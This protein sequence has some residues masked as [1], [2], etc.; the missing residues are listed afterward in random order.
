MAMN[1]TKFAAN[2]RAIA[3]LYKEGVVNFGKETSGDNVVTLTETI[4]D[5]TGG[6]RQGDIGKAA[7]GYKGDFSRVTK[8][9]VKAML[10]ALIL[11]Y[12][13][14]I[15]A[16]VKSSVAGAIPYIMQ[17]LITQNISVKTRGITFDT[18][19]TE[20]GTGDADV[21]RLTKNEFGEI[22]E[23]CYVPLDITIEVSKDQSD[24]LEPYE[25]EFQFSAPTA[26]NLLEQSGFGFPET[27]PILRALNRDGNF[28]KN[29]SWQLGQTAGVAITDPAAA[30][31]GLWVDSTATYGS[32]RYAFDST[33]TYRRSVE[34]SAN[35]SVAISLEVK[36][37]HTIQQPLTGLTRGAPY[38][39][40]F[41]VMRKSS[42]DATVT[43]SVGSNDTAALDLTTISNDTW[44]LVVPTL[45]ENLFQSNFVENDLVA[46]IAGSG[47]TTGTFKIDTVEMY[48]MVSFNGTWWAML[49]NLTPALRNAT[50]KTYLLEDV[51]AGSDANINRM[52]G[53][54][55]G[56]FFPG[57]ATPS[58]AAV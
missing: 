43:M 9:R 50:P 4:K 11:D 40:A 10:E 36:G 22:I 38:F 32:A 54:V 15:G 55:L 57:E 53:A 16:K 34:E 30:D 58:I 35:S 26:E 29:H 42:C 2:L 8:D 3:D 23:S 28:I 41:R 52:L 13:H 49:A 31:F 56:I 20:T 18:S 19:T 14:F 6:D 24:G 1:E 12:A 5:L 45:D 46:K 27:S 47:L 7:T 33:D 39:W 17:H 21:Y 48:Q 25:E 44:T 37:N 51:L